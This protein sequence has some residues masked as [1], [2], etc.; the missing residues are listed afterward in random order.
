MYEKPPTLVR[1][2]E[3][4]CCIVPDAHMLLAHFCANAARLAFHFSGAIPPHAAVRTWLWWSTTACT[5]AAVNDEPVE[6]VAAT[7]HCTVELPGHTPAYHVPVHV[8]TVL[9]RHVPVWPE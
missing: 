9:S 4:E 6:D 3:V 2:V 8:E 5:S 1:C 7:Q